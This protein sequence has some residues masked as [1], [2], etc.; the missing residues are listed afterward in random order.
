MNKIIA[1]VLTFGMVPAFAY[2]DQPK[3]RY[4]VN[5]QQKPEVKVKKECHWVN[6]HKECTITRY[7]L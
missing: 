4:P 5:I 3:P 1:L 6:G 7:V 2:A